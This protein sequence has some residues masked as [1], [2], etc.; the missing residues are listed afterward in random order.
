MRILIIHFIPIKSS[1]M[2]VFLKRSILKTFFSEI[3]FWDYVGEDLLTKNIIIYFI[4]INSNMIGN[5]LE[6]LSKFF[7]FRDF[8][9]FI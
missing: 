6:N 4:S 1:M 5:L 7:L 8:S 9:G 2:T 3:F